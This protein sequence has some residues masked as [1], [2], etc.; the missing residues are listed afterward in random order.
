MKGVSEG[1]TLGPFQT[2][3][4]A[5]TEWEHQGLVALFF[6]RIEMVRKVKG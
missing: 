5:A 2:Q 3:L 1:E 4:T 6:N